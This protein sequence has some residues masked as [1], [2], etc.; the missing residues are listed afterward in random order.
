MKTMK[1][2]CQAIMRMVLA[3]SMVFGTGICSVF[4]DELESSNLN[5]ALDS[6]NAIVTSLTTNRQSISNAFDLL[7][8]AEE[9]DGNNPDILIEHID[10]II[11]EEGENPDLEN[12]KTL[13]TDAQSLNAEYIALTDDEKAIYDNYF[14]ELILEDYVYSGESY[15]D[16]VNYY[17]KISNIILDIG[18]ATANANA[19]T[20]SSNND[21]YSL[22]VNGLELDVDNLT[23][24]IYVGYEV[25]DLEVIANAY[26]SGITNVEIIKPNTLI[27]GENEVKVIVTSLNGQ[28]KEYILTVI[29]Q[30]QSADQGDPADE[31]ETT[32]TTDTKKTVVTPLVNESTDKEDTVTSLVST[33]NN[34]SDSTDDSDIDE[35][36]DNKSNNKKET[37]KYDEE[38]EEESGLN[39]LTVLLIVGG[40]A[41]IGFGIYM[42]FGDKDDNTV[43]IK[44]TNNKS[45]QKNKK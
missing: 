28:V 23:L 41:L 32:N 45:N 29:R 19:I 22:K 3:I 6:Q 12:L 13:I 39:G 27:V 38:V 40:I 25:E 43:G 8:E 35:K 33:T 42:L 31:K 34:V 36:T 20:I 21:L 7:E 18:L 4:A 14:E 1:K 26:M 30:N 37:K 9:L 2:L 24:T 16:I 15:E 11:Q 17:A 5:N 44:K 10:Y